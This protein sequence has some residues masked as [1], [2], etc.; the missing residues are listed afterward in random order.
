MSWQSLKPRYIH[1]EL[2]TFCNA[3][4]P[5]CPRYYEGTENVRPDLNLTQITFENFKRY[6]SIDLIKDWYKVLFCG[7][8]GDPINAKDCYEIIEY[9]NQINSSCEIVV[10]TNGGIRKADFWSKMGRLFSKPNLKLVFSIDGLEDTNHLYRRNV[11]WT[12]LITN[13]E[14]FIK[15]GGT[16]IW[17]YLVFKHNE[18]Q[19]DQAIDYSK[20]LGFKEFRIKRALG[21]DDPVNHRLIP[22]MVF[23]R[24]GQLQYKIYPTSKKELLNAGENIPVHD[25]TYTVDMSRLRIAKELKY[26]HKIERAVRQFD[27]EQCQSLG[28]Y[29]DTLN[30][31]DIKCKSHFDHFTEVYV[32]A[33]GIVFP[34]CFVGTRFDG[35]LDNFMDHQLKAKIRPRLL[36]L[37]LNVRSLEEI[38]QSGVLEEIFSNSWSKHSIQHGKLAYCSETCGQNSPLDKLYV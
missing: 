11:D 38:I 9:I 3:A 15:S 13:V 14:N 24:E 7:T 32:N 31:K 16:A 37:D 22:R 19:I 2:T 35:S 29:I 18:H 34:C 10:H 12:T 6:F 25:H 28:S 4:C 5:M 23:D 17:E 27:D 33:S 26:F 30:S 21:F 8:M 36:D 20:Q 1:I